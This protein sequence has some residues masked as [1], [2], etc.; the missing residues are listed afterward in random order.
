MI[1][2]LRCFIL[3]RVMRSEIIIF[4]AS[5]ITCFISDK[6]RL[7]SSNWNSCL[8][9]PSIRS[10]TAFTTCRFHIFHKVL[11]FSE[12]MVRVGCY[13]IWTHWLYTQM[14]GTEY[15]KQLVPTA[16]FSFNKWQMKHMIEFTS[17]YTGDFPS[18]CHI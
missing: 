13:M 17:T 6:E 7:S 3:T 5:I 16:F 15:I 4:T 11:V 8:S 1:H 14:V 18:E 2:I 12:P 9:T 10:V